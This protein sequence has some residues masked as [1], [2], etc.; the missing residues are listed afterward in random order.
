MK[1]FSQAELIKRLVWALVGYFASLFGIVDL[2]VEPI[3]AALL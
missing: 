3:A 1:K 2:P